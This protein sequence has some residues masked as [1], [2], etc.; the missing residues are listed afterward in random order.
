[1]SALLQTLEAEA[2]S[3]NTFGAPQVLTALNPYRK[4]Q[5][6]ELWSVWKVW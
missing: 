3:Q 1:M 4:T 2:D 6:R 5:L